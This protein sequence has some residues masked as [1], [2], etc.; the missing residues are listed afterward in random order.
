[1][2]ISVLW[3]SICFCVFPE[4]LRFPLGE[5]DRK[6]GRYDSR[7]NRVKDRYSSWTNKYKKLSIF[8]GHTKRIFF[9]DLKTTECSNKLGSDDFEI[10][11]VM[12]FLI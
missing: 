6:I 5:I 2:E 10:V 11:F 4:I 1:M 9:M 12:I 8:P 7:V 3:F